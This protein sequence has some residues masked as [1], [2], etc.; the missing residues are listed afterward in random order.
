MY[1]LLSV[2]VVIGFAV[3]VVLGAALSVAGDLLALT[4]HRSPSVFDA[5]REDD[6]ESEDWDRRNTS[7]YVDDA[8][9][10]R[11]AATN[12]NAAH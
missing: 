7:P 9:A 2:V 12:M 4:K 3:V 5:L 10:S 11:T 6:Q 1:L 8:Q